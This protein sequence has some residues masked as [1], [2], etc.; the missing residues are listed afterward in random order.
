MTE[1]ELLQCPAVPLAN[2]L[3]VSSVR[4]VTNS[5]NHLFQGSHWTRCVAAPCDLA[6]AV[7]SEPVVTFPAAQH[8]RL[9]SNK[10][11]CL[12]TGT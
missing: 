10:L 1:S 8:R 2:A 7:N 5:R 12:V 11:Y 4:S 6:H 9:A 3:D